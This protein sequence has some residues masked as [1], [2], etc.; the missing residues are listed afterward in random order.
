MIR[1]HGNVA[2]PE[3]VIAHSDKIKFEHYKANTP[4]KFQVRTLTG[5]DELMESLSALI[6]LPRNTLDFV[7]FSVCKGAEPH[8]DKLNP[9]KFT[10]TTFVIPTILPKG[11]SV[12]TA[13]GQEAEVKVEGSTSSTTP[14]STR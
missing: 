11:R 8:T 2:I 14:R 7:Y 13:E 3:S 4:E 10:D 6:G 12:I 9:N 1:Y 5:A